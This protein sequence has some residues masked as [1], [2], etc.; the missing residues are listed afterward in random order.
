MRAYNWPFLAP[1]GPEVL[2]NYDMIRRLVDLSI[3]R[4][5]LD[6]GVYDAPEQ[7]KDDI[8]VMFRSCYTFNPVGS[9]AY[10]AGKKVEYAFNEGWNVPTMADSVGTK[11]KMPI[12]YSGVCRTI[13]FPDL[14]RRGLLPR[15]V[16][17]GCFHDVLHLY[18]VWIGICNRSRLGQRTLF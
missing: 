10:E 18:D 13:T 4:R 9:D 7:F 1:V 5:M 11:V 12:T 6:D 17:Y 8:A 14:V 15:R 3:I 2:G 16:R